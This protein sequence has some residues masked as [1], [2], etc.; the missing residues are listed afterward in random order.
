MRSWKALLGVGAA[1][2]A[3][4]AVPLMGGAAALTAGTAT[5]AAAGSALLACA[6]EFLPLGLALLAMAS[7]GG[8]IWWRRRASRATHQATGCGG[9]CH[10]NGG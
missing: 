2:A 10:A 9:A 6:D 3:C 4:C 7:A 1:C 5:L 8:L